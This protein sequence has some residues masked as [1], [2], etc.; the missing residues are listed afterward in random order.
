[1]NKTETAFAARLEAL[2][3]AGEIIRWDREGITL[4]WPDGMTY[5]ADFAVIRPSEFGILLVLMETKG[6]FLRD[7]S[8]VKFRAARAYWPEFEFELHQF[9]RGQW[10]R[11]L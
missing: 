2:K 7:D 3:R 10:S 8:L 6:A 11:I 1:M 5:S 4:R 9:K